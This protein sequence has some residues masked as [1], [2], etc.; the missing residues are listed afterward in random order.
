[1]VLVSSRA[2]FK[3]L[4]NGFGFEFW[5][6]RPIA[7]HFWY[8]IVE[9][10]AQRFWSRFLGSP[11]NCPT[12]LV[13][14]SPNNCPT[15]LVLGSSSTWPTVLVLSQGKFKQRL[16]GFGLESCEVQTTAERFWFWILGNSTNCQTFL[17]LHSWNH[18]PTVL[19]LNLGNFKQMSRNIKQTIDSCL[20]FPRFKQLSIVCL[21]FLDICLKFPRVKTNSL[22]SGFNYAI[23]KAF[24]NLFYFWSIFAGISTKCQTPLVLRSW[25]HCPT[26]LVLNRGNFN[27]L[28]FVCLIFL[29]ICLKFP[30]FKTKTVG[31]WFQLHNTQGVW[32]FILVLV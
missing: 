32:Q 4:P 30:R 19:V 3:Q 29:D 2:K 8:C 12:L 13:R 5:E 10:T 11:S 22:G 18:C 15:F 26:V 17:V 16:N 1:M 31:Q 7:K 9:N 21:I 14:E 20:K 28:S 24:G 25:N 23:P 27:Q 6:I